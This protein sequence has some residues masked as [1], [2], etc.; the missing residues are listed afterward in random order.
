MGSWHQLSPESVSVLP[1]PSWSPTSCQ[2]A[3]TAGLHSHPPISSPVSP[4]TAPAPPLS[5]T[6]AKSPKRDPNTSHLTEE[7]PAP[8][9]TQSGKSG[10]GRSCSAEQPVCTTL[11]AELLHPQN[12][13]FSLFAK[14]F[15]HFDLGGQIAKEPAT[16]L[17]PRCL[18]SEGATPPMAAGF[19]LLRYNLTH[20]CKPRRDPP[21]ASR[22]LPLHPFR[23]SDSLSRYEPRPSSCHA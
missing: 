1:A 16:R 5:A 18:R 15:R 20:P 23:P 9:E 4:P 10:P 3:S 11:P 8:K 17:P 12:G 21:A 14:V 19:L 7:G 13:L 22:S 6:T 2:D